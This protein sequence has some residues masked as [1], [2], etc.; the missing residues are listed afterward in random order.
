M[1]LYVTNMSLKVSPKNEIKRLRMVEVQINKNLFL[2]L[3]GITV[4]AM[5]MM[6]FGFFTRG[7]FPS[8]K[9]SM[10]YLG[11]VIVYAFH[12]EL[13]RWLGNEKS[14]RQGEY[15]IYGWIALTTIFYI[16]DFA[17]K[18]YF[19]VSPA[20]E[21]IETIKETATLTIEVLVIFMLTRGL[22]ILKTAVE[23]FNEV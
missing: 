14:S 23:R 15:F 12:K 6:I 1:A 11:V 13:I 19:S 18:G 7:E 16:L 17:T 21:T 5:V 22:K 3:S 20:G 4:V 9:M 2:V 8:A 10:F